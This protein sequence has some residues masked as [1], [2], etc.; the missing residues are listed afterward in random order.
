MTQS[1]IRRWGSALGLSTVL[2]IGFI[3]SFSTALIGPESLTPI[4]EVWKEPLARERSP[5]SKNLSHAGARRKIPAS[6]LALGSGAHVG[7]YAMRRN[8]ASVSDGE[9]GDPTKAL[10]RK[11]EA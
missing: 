10:V 8:T 7:I 6:A 5:G 1:D 11:A 3:P 4:V 9:S 2:H